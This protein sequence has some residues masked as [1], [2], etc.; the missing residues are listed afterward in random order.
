MQ[1]LVSI[2][3]PIYETEQYLPQ[4]V[5]SILHQTYQNM[6]IIL[7]DDGS[8]DHCPQICDK[9]AKED[10]RIRVIHQKNAGVSVTRNTGL[11]MA[12]GEWVAFADSDDFCK[13][14][15]ITCM[16]QNAMKMDCELS[17][18]GYNVNY[19][20]ENLKDQQTS[21]ATT[22]NGP[23]MLLD[24]EETI[25]CAFLPTGCQ[26]SIWNK[27]FKRSIICDHLI[28]FEPSISIGE[29][30]VFLFSYLRFC[31]KVVYDPTPLYVY[32]IHVGSAMNAMSHAEHFQKK[33]LTDLD[34]HKLIQAY[35]P[36]DERLQNLLL[37]RIVR[38]SSNYVNLMV[39]HR[40]WKPK[41]KELLRYVRAHLNV[42]LRSS[43]YSPKTKLGVF[44]YAFF[45]RLGYWKAGG[46]FQSRIRSF[47]W[48]LIKWRKT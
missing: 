33:W 18:C 19:E 34:A 30:M 9:Y 2:I 36:K 39:P 37:A 22:R 29:D 45:P 46:R 28:A 31:K 4:C 42:F 12:R 25:Y 21:Q 43:L 8:P 7:V 15:W 1:P 11:S 47:D 35:L 13:P 44:I 20:V 5:D 41:Q 27:L 14:M 26:V 24:R 40:E 6:E 17:I 3:V 16:I 48:R 10:S 32:M 38:T 23:P